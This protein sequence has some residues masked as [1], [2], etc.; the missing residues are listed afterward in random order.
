MGESD[1]GKIGI[2]ELIAGMAAG[3]DI[4][5]T[6][7]AFKWEKKPPAFGQKGL[8]FDLRIY[9]GKR[10]EVLSFSEELVRSSAENVLDFVSAYTD[11]VIAAFRRLKRPEKRENSNQG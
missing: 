3:L 6:K 7:L 10:S 1:P 9:L 2:Q 11:G 5:P 8:F 4:D